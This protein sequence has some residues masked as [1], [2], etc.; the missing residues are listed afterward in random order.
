[1]SHNRNKLHPALIGSSYKTCVNHSE[2][3][4]REQSTYS[5]YHLATPIWPLCQ[6]I[7]NRLVLTVSRTAITLSTS[8]LMLN[9]VKTFSSVHSFIVHQ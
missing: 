2:G 3:D 7:T 9:L 5:H 6:I 8:T 1:M 4:T